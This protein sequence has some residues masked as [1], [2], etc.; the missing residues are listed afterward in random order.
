MIR[1]IIE[2]HY[3]CPS[4]GV[5][6]VTYETLDLNVPELEQALTSGGVAETHWDIRTF[7]GIEIL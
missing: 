2:R 5:E 3:K 6:D 7:K 4:S 1:F